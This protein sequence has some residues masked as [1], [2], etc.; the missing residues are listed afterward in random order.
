VARTIEIIRNELGV[1][2]AFTS[3]T[4]IN[5]IDRRFLVHYR[6]APAK[7]WAGLLTSAPGTF[8]P[9]RRPSEVVGYAGVKQSVRSVG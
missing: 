7:G 4:R 2:T 9:W 5:D 1:A 6:G 3:R 8:A